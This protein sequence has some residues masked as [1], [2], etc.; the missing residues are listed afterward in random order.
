MVVENIVQVKEVLNSDEYT[1]IDHTMSS[2][3][4]LELGVGQIRLEIVIIFCHLEVSFRVVKLVHI[5]V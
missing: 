1:G 4:S 5:V 3:E 2:Q